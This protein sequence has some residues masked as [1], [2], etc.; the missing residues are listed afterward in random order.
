MKAQAFQLALAPVFLL[1]GIAGMLS[2]MAGRLARIFDRCSALIENENILMLSVHKTLELEQQSLEK[3]R[4]ITSVAMTASTISALLVCLDIAVIFL[5]L[6]F[7][8]PLKWPIGILFIAAV[9]LLIVGLASFLRE[10]HL[11]MKT[12]HITFPGASRHGTPSNSE[13]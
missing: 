5:E 1:T 9:L 8:K 4:H 2:V 7:D 10:V 13:R 11:A 3:R 12:T 6:M